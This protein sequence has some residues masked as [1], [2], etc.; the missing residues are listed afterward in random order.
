MLRPMVRQA[1]RI[2]ALYGSPLRFELVAEE[3][4]G[5]LR[6]G[7]LSPGDR[8]PAERDLCQ[9][10]AVSRGTVR[11][12]LGRLRDLGLIRPAAWGWIVCEPS[13]GEPTAVLIFSEMPAE[14]GAAAP[15]DVRAERR[16]RGSAREAP[17]SARSAS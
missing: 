4:R 5:E 9:R 8:L 15:P 13:P 3:L 2:G 12:A 1:E 6:A 14:T 16:R 7:S 17:S 11:R 10:F